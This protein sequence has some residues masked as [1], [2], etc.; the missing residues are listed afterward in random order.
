MGYRHLIIAMILQVLRDTHAKG[1]D[2]KTWLRREKAKN[3]M[4]TR[5]WDLMNKSL[6]RNGRKAKHSY[7]VRTP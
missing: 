2:N 3:F 5:T 6:G 1:D 4:K 7:C